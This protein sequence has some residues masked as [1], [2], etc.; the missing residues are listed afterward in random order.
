MFDDFQNNLPTIGQIKKYFSA[1]LV[2]QLIVFLI[3]LIISG[4]GLI[5]LF[6]SDSQL[7]SG[8]SEDSIQVCDNNLEFGQLTVDIGG[9]VKNPGIYQLETGARM[10]DL[11]IVA[12]GFSN[13]V[14]KYYINKVLNLSQPLN[15]GEKFYIPT[16]EESAQAES[17]QLSSNSSKNG[18]TGSSIIAIS[19]NNASKEELTSLVGIGEKRAEDIVAER[20]YDSINQ[21]VEKG[22]LTEAALDKIK[23]DIS[24]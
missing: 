14:D 24:L 17:Q 7:S 20:P 12:G 22:V 11:V 8:E 2:I 15:D 6:L 10:N 5:Q 19:I 9:A 4:F 13:S 18:N 23:N 16:L 3:G 21:L 1:R